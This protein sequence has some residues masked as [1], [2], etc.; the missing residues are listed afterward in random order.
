MSDE[1]N[2]AQVP[3]LPKDRYLSAARAMKNG[4][5]MQMRIDSLTGN[6]DGMVA[7]HNLR[8]GVNIAG[9]DHRALAELLI[10]KGLITRFEYEAALAASMEQETEMHKRLLEKQTKGKVDLHE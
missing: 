5:L 9:V 10:A 4:V 2:N 7:P 3:M 6:R 8:V 1:Q